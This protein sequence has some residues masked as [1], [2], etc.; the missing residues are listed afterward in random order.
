MGILAHFLCSELNESMKVETSNTINT[1]YLTGTEQIPFAL[2]HESFINSLEEATNRARHLH[3][4]ILASFTQKFEWHD[5][6]EAFNSVRLAELG[7]C[8]FWEQPEEQTALIGIGSV[9]SI[10]TNGT[11]CFTDSA[12]RWRDL[13][14][15]AVICYTTGTAHISGS[16]PAMFGGFAFDPLSPRTESWMGFPDGLLILPHF[17]LSYDAQYVTV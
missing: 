2:D 9:T 17:L 14:K 6:V 3:K 13:M 12:T 10:E 15:D 7:E 1:H 4:S 8:F 11:T 5:T 16:G